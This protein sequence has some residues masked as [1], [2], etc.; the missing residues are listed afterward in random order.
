MRASIPVAAVI[1]DGND[2]VIAKS[3]IAT[4]GMIPSVDNSIFIFLSVSVITE[5]LVASLPV[6]AVVGIAIMGSD[7][8]SGAVF[9]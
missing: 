4:F 2:F 7:S 9:S 8:F 3:R 6:P 1:N 5:Y